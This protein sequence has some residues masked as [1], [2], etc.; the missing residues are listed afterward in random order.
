MR[1]GTVLSP[2]LNPHN[3][4][5][6]AFW[7]ETINSK[8]NKVLLDMDIRDFSIKGVLIDDHLGLSDPDELVR[9]SSILEID[10]QLE[11]KV[12]LA[13][14]RK[15]GKV[16][17]Y[18]VDHSGLFIQKIYVQPPV[19]KP[20]IGGTRLTFDRTSIIE[21]T[22]THIVVSGPEEKA[23]SSISLKSKNALANYSASTSLM[24][25]KE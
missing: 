8:T 1:I 13:S 6:D 11:G 24:S 12:V 10:Y 25:E 22:D 19:W 17:D 9:L 23:Q 21:V 15:I 14:K 20:S 7:C 5:I 18:A 4:H 3:L 16:V 2:I